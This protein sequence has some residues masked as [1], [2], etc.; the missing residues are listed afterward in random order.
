MRQRGKSVAPRSLRGPLLFLAVL[1]L[2]CCL[3]AGR[4]VAAAPSAPIVTT[5]TPIPT[6]TPSPLELRQNW[7]LTPEAERAG[8]LISLP[9]VMQSGSG[10]AEDSSTHADPASFTYVVQA[11][12]TLWSLALDF[13]RDLEAMSC[14][15][16]P[17]GSDAETLTPGQTITVPALDDLCYTVTPGDTLASIAAQNGL[18]VEA[19]VAIPWNSFSGPPYVVR[20]RQ[21]VLL[22]GARAEAKPRP[23]HRAVSFPS[24]AWAVTPYKDWP[25]GDGKF[26]WPVTGWISQGARPGHVALDIAVPSGTPVK[27]ADRGKVIM[28]GWNPTGYGFRV[29]IDHGIDYATL[30]AH[31]SD[32]YVKVGDVVGKGQ[33][34]GASGANGNITGPHLH[35]EIRDFGRLT[36]PLPLLPK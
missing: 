8:S 20:P 25:Y 15:T 34:I 16:T 29:V 23:D 28:A 3:A 11:D 9:L 24:D 31:L 17:T 1:F 7:L 36:D 2:L 21:R 4:P 6:P 5:P 13:G 27:A 33:V 26:V 14:T 32:I 19:I 18:T 12:D 22:P 30:Y 35:F 10:G